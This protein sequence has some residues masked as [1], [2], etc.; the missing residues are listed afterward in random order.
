MTKG[1]ILK[2]CPYIDQVGISCDS[3]DDNVQKSIG[4]GFGNHVEVTKRA[5]DRIHAFNKNFDQNVRVKLNTVVMKQN[6]QEDWSD[7]ILEHGV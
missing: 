7:F 5:L 1:W 2:N 4:R 3:L 6:Y